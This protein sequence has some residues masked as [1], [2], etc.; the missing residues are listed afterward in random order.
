[1]RNKVQEAVMFGNSRYKLE[2]LVYYGEFSGKKEHLS[3]KLVHSFSK[4]VQ[5]I[6]S[7]GCQGAAQGEIF[8]QMIIWRALNYTSTML[9]QQRFYLLFTYLLS[10]PKHYREERVGIIQKTRN[11]ADQSYMHTMAVLK[12]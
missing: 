10:R 1:M 8:P 9:T 5:E 3:V 11:T 4:R 7:F 6:G 12:P 2:S